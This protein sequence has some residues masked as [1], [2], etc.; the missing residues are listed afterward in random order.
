MSLLRH[1]SSVRHIPII[2][3][4]K[5]TGVRHSDTWS[6]VFCLV[7][8]VDKQN[9]PIAVGFYYFSGDPKPPIR[10]TPTWVY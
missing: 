10:W 4:A 5:H 6:N 3:R 2:P 1:A 7:N 8:G 9:P